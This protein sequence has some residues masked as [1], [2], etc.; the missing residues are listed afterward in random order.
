MSRV[1]AAAAVVS[2]VVFA[3][4]V[5]LMN[6]EPSSM[7]IRA[8]VPAGGISTPVATARDVHAMAYGGTIILSVAADANIFGAGHSVPPAP[9]GWGAGTLPPGIGFVPSPDQVL[10]LSNVTGCV[11][12]TIGFGT[13]D[14]A[15]GDAKNVFETDITSYGGISGI[16]HDTQ[17]FLVGVFLNSSEPVD[18]APP[19]LDFRSSALG[20]NFTTLSPV[21]GQTFFVGDGLNGTGTGEVQRFA[22]PPM[23]A[24]LFLGFA[25]AYEYHG[26]PGAYVDNVGAIQVTFATIPGTTGVQSASDWV[27]PFV[28]GAIGGAVIAGAAAA[29]YVMVPR[30]RRAP[31]ETRPSER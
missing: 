5:G 20:T 9:A 10:T 21:L 4:I 13:C 22:V 29:A 18:P 25:D 14:G 28:T 19:I 7:A 23:A 1:A 16:H 24:R 26:L 2:V 27:W 11:T 6:P 30:R 17:G 3:S 15:D 31:A 12:M 8:P